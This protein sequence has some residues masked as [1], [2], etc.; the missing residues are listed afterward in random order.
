MKFCSVTSSESW[1]YSGLLG[2]E[3]SCCDLN[4]S[5]TRNSQS[6]S[7]FSL[8]DDTIPL[9]SPPKTL[10]WIT[11]YVT[12]ST[13]CAEFCWVLLFDLQLCVNKFSTGFSQ[14]NLFVCSHCVHGKQEIFKGN[15]QCHWLEWLVRKFTS[16]TKAHV[17]TALCTPRI[18]HI[19]E[20]RMTET[21]EWEHGQCLALPIGSHI[22]FL[23]AVICTLE[24]A[25]NS[26]NSDIDPA[27]PANP[28]PWCAPLVCER[29][30][31]TSPTR[32]TLHF[33]RWLTHLLKPSQ[34]RSRK[35]SSQRICTATVPSNKRALWR[36]M[37]DA[38]ICIHTAKVTAGLCSSGLAFT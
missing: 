8:P 12:L 2:S 36:P 34:N 11:T 37:K 6:S 26:Y 27:N 28:M 18:K 33:R 32:G 13:Q 22:S 30:T 25:L 21:E 9:M 3:T 16:G 23:P 24:K 19:W 31:R 20:Q 38:L 29:Q 7:I 35:H 10:N 14:H 15:H 17:Q 4:C 1:P 5:V